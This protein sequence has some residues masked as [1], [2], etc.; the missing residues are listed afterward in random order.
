[1]YPDVKLYI[2]FLPRVN[3]LSS[4]SFLYQLNKVVLV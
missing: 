3:E 4:M 1:M 2:K